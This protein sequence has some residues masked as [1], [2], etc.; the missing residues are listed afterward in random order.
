MIIRLLPDQI[1]QLWD[2]IKVACKESIHINGDD[3]LVY[4]NKLLHLLLS[5]R[6]QCFVELNSDRR[7]VTIAV[8]RIVIDNYS[9]DK[10]LLM[11]PVY[12]FEKNTL[13]GLRY[14]LDVIKKF[15]SSNECTKLITNSRIEAMY[16]LLPMLGF[17]EY[18]RNFSVNTRS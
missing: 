12:A 18:S 11:E 8:T 14:A 6:A 7:V 4:T 17:E 15:A 2:A 1:P 10:I 3:L 5:D 9:N 16:R 13:N